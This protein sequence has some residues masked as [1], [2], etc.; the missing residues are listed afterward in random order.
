MLVVFVAGTHT[1]H[2]FLDRRDPGPLPSLLGSG[3]K[4]VTLEYG[5]G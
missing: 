4:C 2:S 1:A 3:S 5:P